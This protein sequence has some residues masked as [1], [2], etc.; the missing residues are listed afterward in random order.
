[1]QISI[2]GTHGL[3][4]K[5]GG[6]DQLVNNL[7]EKANPKLNY[8]VFNPKETK[9]TTYIPKNCKIIEIPLSA[10]GY[11]GLFYDFLSILIGFFYCRNQLLLGI[12]GVPACSFLKIVSF[13]RLKFAVNIGG[14]EWERPQFSFLIKT[15]LKFCFFLA[16]KFADTIIID[17]EH[18]LSYFN[19]DDEIKNLEVISYG[20]FID[21]TFT[22]ANESLKIKYPFINNE[23]YL[24]ISRSIEDN[25][26][27][28]LCDLFKNNL[29]NKHL[30]LISNLS[31][32]NYGKNILL[33]FSSAENISLID[34]LYLKKELD[35]IRRKC[36]AYI[37]THTLCG[38]APSLIEMIFADVPIL[39]IDVPQNRLTLDG[40]GIFF[41]QF[42]KLID[43]IRND[44]EM[45]KPAEELKL[46]Y[47]WKN[48]VKQYES[49]FINDRT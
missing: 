21:K 49:C 26:L 25:K 47:E 3:Y 5:Y 46:K 20:G 45:Y 2:I 10:S 43:L 27:F 18:Y 19:K 4:A 37:H 41:N 28:E 33:E 7:V 8:I 30:V 9:K 24:S 35:L 31:N 38:S 39:S 48:I 16:K 44:M 15:Y 17:N 12:Q 22:E 23:Y 34:G 6:W 40:N 14:I 1:M 13:N 32:S 29:E 36:R 42:E 11:Q